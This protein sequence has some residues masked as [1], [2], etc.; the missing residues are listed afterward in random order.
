M[1][2]RPDPLLG[3]PPA[4]A[5]RSDSTLAK[6]DDTGG[7]GR[8]LLDVQW[9]RQGNIRG[10]S[11]SDT[12]GEIVNNQATGVVTVSRPVGGTRSQMASEQVF[13]RSGNPFSPQNVLS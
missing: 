12:G 3:P 2:G 10:S 4:G 11:M 5:A 1:R 13:C 7:S 8:Y 6:Y 9:C